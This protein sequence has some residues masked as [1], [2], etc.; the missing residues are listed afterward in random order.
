MS[1]TTAPYAISAMVWGG[2]G[3]TFAIMPFANFLGIIFS[4]IGLYKIRRGK[5]LYMQNPE[6]YASAGLYRAAQ[7]CSIIGLIA[8]IIG[9]VIWGFLLIVWI[10]TGY[11]GY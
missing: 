8:G 9:A 4:A 10:S 5:N 6:I 1:R 3:L 2:L 7:I 11:I